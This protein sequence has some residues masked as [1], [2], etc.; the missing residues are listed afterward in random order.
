MNTRFLDTLK[1][2]NDTIFEIEN[3]QFNMQLLYRGRITSKIYRLSIV[4]KRRIESGIERIL[5]LCLNKSYAYQFI[6]LKIRLIFVK[7]ERKKLYAP[8]LRLG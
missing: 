1:E 4:S 7:S 8:I 6:G 2:T 5:S 3:P